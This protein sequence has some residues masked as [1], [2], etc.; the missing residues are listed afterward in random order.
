M[1]HVLD[2]LKHILSNQNFKKHF[3]PQHQKG[4][5]VPINLQDR[6]KTEIK[7]ITYRRIYRKNLTTVQINI[8]FHP[9][10]LQ[11]NETKL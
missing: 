10:L 3:Q 9:L 8:L 11:L 4:R 2:G 1:F 7:K 6:F 5:R